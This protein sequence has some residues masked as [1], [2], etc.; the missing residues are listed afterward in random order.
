MV[1]GPSV[2]A[3]AVVFD[4]P[5]R[6]LAI[7]DAPVCIA[8]AIGIRIRIEQAHHLFIYALIAVVIDPVADLLGPG[9]DRG[10]GVIAV[11]FGA[12]PITV[13]VS[14][15]GIGMSVGH[16]TGLVGAAGEGKNKESRQQ[17]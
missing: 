14:E 13:C 11:L 15:A 16:P 4:I 8:K 3:V 2:V 6:G 12:V 7:L 1:L 10:I 5:A 17:A 9:M